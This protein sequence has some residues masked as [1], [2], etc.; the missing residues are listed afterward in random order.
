MPTIAYKQVLDSG[1]TLKQPG[2]PLPE[3]AGTSIAN[4]LKN[5]PYRISVNLGK[6]YTEEFKEFN[7]WCE[8]NLG[9]KYKDWFLA[10]AGGVRN[11]KYTLYLKDTKKSMFLALKFSESIDETSF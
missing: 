2:A 5:F 7:Q 1:G 11:T 4:Y 6:V 3:G 8:A 9:T 10:G